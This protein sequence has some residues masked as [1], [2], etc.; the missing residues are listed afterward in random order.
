MPAKAPP[1]TEPARRVTMTDV[2]TQAAV[3]QSTV[4]LVL[5]GM[6]GT[7]LSDETRARVLRVAAELGYRLPDRRGTAAAAGRRGKTRMAAT[8]TPLILYLVDEV[9]TSPHPVLSID[10]A[11]DEAWNQGALVAVFATR[12]NAGIEAAVLSTMLA[13]PAL[14]GVIYSTIFTRQVSVPPQLGRVPTVLLN[15]SE[16]EPASGGEP[17]FSS[18]EP[19]EVLGGFVATECLLDA[20]HRRIAFI[21]GEPWMDAARDRLKGYRRALASADIAYDAALVREGDWQVASGHDLTLSLMKQPKPPTAVFCAND[22]MAVGC[23]EALRQLGKQVPHDVAVIGYDDQ[24]IARH[25]SPPLTTLVLPNYEMGRLAVEMLL[26]QVA[27]PDG[28]RRR[29]KV[30]GRLVPRQTVG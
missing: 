28:R 18:V 25:T 15:C 16:A 3:S 23:L 30:D 8:S 7:Q 10:G 13:N 21:N 2:A 27:A 22:L 12:S 19:S 24:E 11:K 29:V 14:I 17:R 9:S 4:S 26:A 5:N 1:A 6:T 20:G